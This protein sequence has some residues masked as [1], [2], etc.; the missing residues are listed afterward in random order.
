MSRFA[1]SEMEVVIPQLRKL[2]H[3]QSS[4]GYRVILKTDETEFEIGSV[5]TQGSIDASTVWTW[6]IDTV[7]PMQW[8]GTRGVWNGPARLHAT[9]RRCVGALRIRSDQI[10]TVLK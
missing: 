8:T 6:G 7:V 5:G 10:G 2:D 3:P 1:K 9:V 4:N